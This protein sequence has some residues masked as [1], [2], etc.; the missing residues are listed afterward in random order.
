MIKQTQSRFRWATFA[1]LALI[2]L[3]YVAKAWTPSSYAIVLNSMG[4]A[5]VGPA[6][7]IARDI[8]SDEYFVQTP[9]FQM[10]VLGGFK[11]TDQI[12]PYHESM[13]T[14]QAYPIKD[15][16]A[17]FKPHLWGF[18]FLGAD[19]AY[20][21]YFA[22]LAMSFLVGWWLFFRLL[23]I[24]GKYAFL[25]S[26]L[27]LFS[28]FIQVW[29][30]T[31]AAAFA[32]APW[33]GVAFLLPK[34]FATR[35]LLVLYSSAVWLFGLLYPPFLYAMALV[36]ATAVLAL[37]PDA[38]KFRSIVAALIGGL[39]AG[40]LVFYYLHDIV[41]VMK[42]TIY[43]GQRSA[44]GG[45]VPIGQVI[46][47]FFPYINTLQFD[48]IPINPD[49][50][51]AC[52]VGTISSYLALTMLCF[53][54]M[55]T[56]IDAVRDYQRALIILLVAAIFCCVWLIAPVPAR[57]GHLVLLDMAP[58]RRLLLAFGF[59]VHIA[60][61]IL[62]PKLR[63]SVTLRRVAIFA[64][65]IG[66]SFW[67]SKG[68]LP[69][70]LLV[71]NWF[72]LL[73][74]PLVLAAIALGYFLRRPGAMG[75]LL[76]A[77]ITAC[78]LLTFGTFNPLQS[79]TP[80]FDFHRSDLVKDLR[81]LGQVD[82]R[83]WVY[84]IG[85]YGAALNGLGVTAIDHTP[86]SPQQAF[87]AREFPELPSETRNYDFNRYAHIILAFQAEPSVFQDQVFVPL[88]HFAR[89]DYVVRGT[90]KDAL[91][92]AGSI[93]GYAII[94]T[95]PGHY[96]VEVS[97]WGEFTSVNAGQKLVFS[98][99]SFAPT[100]LARDLRLDVSTA[101]KDSTMSLSGFR[102]F[103]ET[104]H[105]NAEGPLAFATIDPVR[106]EH[107]VPNLI[108]A[109]F[110]TEAPPS[111]G[112]KGVDGKGFVDSVTVRRDSPSSL[113]ID[114]SGW[115]PFAS[116]EGQ[117]IKVVSPAHVTSM[118]LRRVYRGDLTKFL[119]PDWGMSGFSI[120][121]QVEDR[122]AF[123]VGSLC[124]VAHDQIVGDVALHAGSKETQELCSA[125]RETPTK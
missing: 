2:F 85:G 82:P 25:G 10:A 67:L 58:P 53:A 117:S 73:I 78:N 46:A 54:E 42:N 75:V 69:F 112:L 49:T 87:F 84:L 43:P 21:L 116:R 68:K 93:D 24:E 94:E 35:A 123:D 20:S 103:F 107:R 125:R 101:R 110:T 37:R 51:D 50:I 34:S 18:F 30:T 83:G 97:G 1:A 15:W 26:A 79:A 56:L 62:L 19:H 65:C 14:F 33:V 76:L 106:G 7:G 8:R 41:E 59:I 61:L 47:T 45:D 105:P 40:A 16:S 119:G 52:E 121:M 38:L 64:A 72:D 104:D 66:V 29:W 13:R 17:L 70:P 44:A 57:I 91:P 12:S 63:W 98:G 90:I 39:F 88:Q 89:N 118:S 28:H 6:L 108:T 109:Q 115:L 36:M 5:D 86:M 71:Q 55:R 23:G 31:N 120:H 27:L 81:K 102:A 114:I 92:S 22:L 9:H 99:D 3:V 122:V 60:L 80:I 100:G 96:A 48:P 124:V 4:K 77:A 32:F 95:S 111:S 11:D 74:V 113:G